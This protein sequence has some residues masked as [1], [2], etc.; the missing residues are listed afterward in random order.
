MPQHEAMRQKA[1]T[2]VEAVFADYSPTYPLSASPAIEDRVHSL[3][4]GQYPPNYLAH[5]MTTMGTVE[6]FK[7][8]L[9]HILS[10]LAHRGSDF[11]AG[12]AF[13]HKLRYA[14]FTAWWDD[15]Q[16]AV[17][18]YLMA[19]WQT[20]LDRAFHNRHEAAILPREFIR[21]CLRPR[22]YLAVWEQR[23]NER[24]SLRYLAEWINHDYGVLWRGYEDAGVSPVHDHWILH[25]H[26]Q[27]TM[28]EA[29]L[30]Y[31]DTHFAGEFLAAADHLM[32]LRRYVDLPDLP[33]E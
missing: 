5:A 12:D 31:D 25:P 9:P 26:I 20:L 7:A 1:M 4:R 27:Q 6:D 18:D 24:A 14:N 33:D 3:K 8:F 2:R 28:E 19:L 11:L 30:T 13:F 10:K 21:D 15:E 23:L 32:W 17:N 16:A 22:R 29:F